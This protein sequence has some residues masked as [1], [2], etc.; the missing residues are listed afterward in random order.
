VSR[1]HTA[2][3]ARFFSLTSFTC[4]HTSRLQTFGM[5]TQQLY[6][7]TVVMFLEDTAMGKTI[8]R[9]GD[10]LQKNHI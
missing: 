4:T 7:N 8:F 2:T 5:E 10:N 3:P 1:D 9:K 6:L